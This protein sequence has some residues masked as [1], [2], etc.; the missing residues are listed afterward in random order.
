MSG[1]TSFSAAQ[2]RTSWT[3]ASEGMFGQS[4]RWTLRPSTISVV[5][6]GRS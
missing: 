1:C 2:S 4:E 6:I 5:A 3:S